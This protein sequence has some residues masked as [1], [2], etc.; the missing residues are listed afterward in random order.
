MYLT[1]NGILPISKFLCSYVLIEFSFG[2][3]TMYAY[4]IGGRKIMNLTLF[5]AFPVFN[6]S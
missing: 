6:S 5:L 1:P 4:R 2:L 3:D